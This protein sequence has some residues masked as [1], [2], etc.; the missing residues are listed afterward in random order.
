MD[1]LP[2]LD[3]GLRGA[4]LAL[5][6][7]LAHGLWPWR[8]LAPIARLGLYLCAGL[9]LQLLSSA[10]R[11]EAWAPLAW[12]APLVGLA[13]GNALLFWLFASQLFDDEFRARP[14]HALAWAAA[15]LLG[16][17]N[18]LGATPGCPASPLSCAGLGLQRLLPLFCAAAVVLGA[19]RHWPQDLMEDRRRLRA[20][21]AFGGAAYSLLTISMRLLSQ[22]GRFD[23]RAGL[24]D[25]C[26]LLLLVLLCTR[27]MLRLTPS[28]LLAPSRPQPALPAAQARATQAASLGQGD[29]P[30]A[31]AAPP[32]EPP[33]AFQAELAW[34][35]QRMREEKLYQ[36]DALSIARL[37]QVLSLPEYRLRRLINEGLGYRNFSSFI[38]DWRLQDA[39]AALR[40]P[41]LA[42]ESVLDIAL[43]AGFQ[44]VGPFN[45]AFKARTGLT[46]SEFRRQAL[47]DS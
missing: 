4:A 10:P 18:T 2:L 30:T 22:D 32:A 28:V 39:E 45:R 5:L 29:G 1:G 36:L 41:A 11:F 43:A 33:A 13:V 34:L 12:Q 24:L 37:S 27:T 19:L 6:G 46:P 9:V 21:V 42:K 17:L 23:D 40:N 35:Q 20:L 3:A 25:L 26:A 31:T 15:V 14:R 38:N 8:G 47:A 44:S 16:V 7:V